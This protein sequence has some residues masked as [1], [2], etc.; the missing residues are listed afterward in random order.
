MEFPIC[1]DC[2]HGHLL[3]LS[4]SEQIY[5]LWVCSAPACSYVISRSTLGEVYYKGRA[6]TSEKEKSGKTWTQ[7]DF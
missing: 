4:D 6:T 2:K 7:F 3:P 5:A 1:P